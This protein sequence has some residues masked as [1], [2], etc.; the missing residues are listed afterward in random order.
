M[1][2]TLNKTEIDLIRDAMPWTAAVQ[3]RTA[4][5]AFQRLEA[6]DN[7]P[8]WL[9]VRRGPPN[10]DATRQVAGWHYGRAVIPTDRRKIIY[11]KDSRVWIEVF[12]EFPNRLPTAEG[13]E[14]DP[15]TAEE[16][17][18]HGKVHDAFDV[19]KGIVGLFES[20]DLPDLDIDDSS[21]V[22]GLPRWLSVLHRLH[23]AGLVS[24]GEDEDMIS[25][26]AIHAQ[27]RLIAD[28]WDEKAR[29]GSGERLR[30]LRRIGFGWRIPNFVRYC[31]NAAAVLATIAESKPL[32]LDATQITPSNL[33]SFK[34]VNALPE[35]RITKAEIIA[36][37][38]AIAAVLN[39]RGLKPG[40]VSEGT[41]HRIKQFQMRA[42]NPFEPWHT[43][44]FIYENGHEC[45][46]VKP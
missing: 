17:E 46:V 26:G 20:L 28:S 4:E 24:G 37:V 22:V 43:T 29:I 12:I 18:A 45:R 44:D 5:R 41:K 38:R 25:H 15:Y 27:M 8:V 2:A 21:R 42:G 14:R 33:K 35:P 16:K 11:G 30:Q 13:C 9:T 6:P 31:T 32:L 3:L 36:E 23:H 10:Y 34:P 39:V 7:L 1:T 19:S 40:H